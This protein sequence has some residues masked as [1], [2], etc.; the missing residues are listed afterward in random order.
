MVMQAT[1]AIFS[2]RH[3]PASPAEVAAANK[4][5]QP[6]GHKLSALVVDDA[7]DITTLL[8]HVLRRAGYDV[9]TAFSAPA[10]LAAA[11][12]HSFDLV[13]SDIGMPGMDGYE[14]ATSL[15]ALPAYRSVPMIAVTGFDQ[16]G[17]RERALSAGF[18]AHLGKPLDPAKLTEL[19]ARLRDGVLLAVVFR[20]K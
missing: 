13:V 6:S 5:Q 3:S 7:P 15:R 10:A 20:D 16:H 4:S 9:T 19:I 2:P 17:D 1:G 14:L 12:T 18:N 11:R 8:A